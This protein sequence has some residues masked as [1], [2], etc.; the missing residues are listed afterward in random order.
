MKHHDFQPTIQ[1]QRND[2]RMSDYA[3]SH[4][5]ARKIAAIGNE[6]GRWNKVMAERRKAPRRVADRRSHLADKIIS[7]AACVFMLW[8][9]V[10]LV[11]ST[12]HIVTNPVEI[13]VKK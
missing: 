6:R 13:G 9:A 3:A 2:R 12:G 10:D 5:I 11:R 4:E 1:L 7:A 8:L